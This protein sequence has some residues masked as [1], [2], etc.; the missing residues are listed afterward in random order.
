MNYIEALGLVRYL[1]ATGT[2][3]DEA[4]LN[5]AIPS[6]LR[7]KIKETIKEEE[8]IILQPAKM[9]IDDEEHVEWLNQKDRSEWYYWPTLRQY[10]LTTKSWSNASVQSLD[11]ETDR[12]LGRLAPPDS[13]TAFDKRGLVLG[14]V[15]SGKTSNYTALIAKAADSGYRFFVVLSGIDNG[16]RLQT[17]RRLKSELVGG[18]QGIGVTL[19][20]IGR[21]WHEFT[22]DELHGD[23]R[24]GFVNNAALQGSQPVLLVIKKNGTVLRRLLHWL[25]TGPEDIMKTIP[26]MV[27]DDE[28]DL[29][30]PDT[31]GSYQ[32]EEDPMPE[33]YE[34]PSVINGL[35]RDLLNRF[36]HKVYVAYTATPFA[37]ILI[38][39]DNYDP[40]V[41]DD[42]YPRNFMVDLPKP[43]GYFG[44]EELFGRM[45][46]ISEEAVEGID[47]IRHI[48]DEDLNAL[49]ECQIPTIMEQAILSFILAGAARMHRSPDDFPATMLIHISLRIDDQLQIKAEVEKK[50]TEIR[51]EW[52]YDR[53]KGIYDR[54]KRIWQED[55][56]PVTK[57]QHPSEVVDFDEIE[58]HISKFFESIQI[59]TINSATGEILDYEIEPN[60]KAIAIGGN[61]LS[62]GLTLE[63]LLISVFIRRSVQY[64]TLMQ[65]GRWFGFRAGYDDLTRIYTTPELAQWFSD[66][67]QVECRLREE[68]QIFENQHL[69]PLQVGMK[70]K[71]HPTMQV[72]SPL[73]RRFSSQITI[74]QS[75]SGQIE[76]TIRWPLNRLE[77]LAMLSEKNLVEVKSFLSKLGEYELGKKGPIWS[78]IPAEKILNF[79]EK[80][81][82]DGS[83][84]SISLPLIHSY[85]EKQV[86]NGELVRWN[87]AICGRDKEDPNLGE[88]DWS[89]KTK[90][91]QISRTRVLDTESIKVLRSSSDEKI[92][93]SKEE[94]ERFNEFTKDGDTEGNAARKARSPNNGL[95][96]LYPISRFSRPD[97]TNTTKGIRRPLYNNLDD[98]RVRDLI[99]IAISFPYSTQ[100]QPEV[101]YVVGT[102]PRRTEE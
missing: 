98:P 54:L 64:D 83:S 61:K 46:D 69:T 84:R 20:P 101:S 53:K 13:R 88:V 11:K 81:T 76:Q 33:D 14:F 60:L 49:Q 39:H 42:L 37:N 44:A 36:D 102:V 68:I 19:P 85:I 99:G 17:H 22:R 100:P 48:S 32:S 6:E 27:I 78:E 28:A 51:D 45:D 72:T 7:D 29:A 71:T 73:K 35:I 70:I 15:Q 38:P 1:L 90:I 77:E 58:T 79:L 10:L 52:R 30:S 62:R 4:I 56:V 3:L 41:S 25:K 43:H 40:N 80:F 18:M 94:L 87:V 66:L 26:M 67:A 34:S 89:L 47:V 9:V 24:P 74:S 21:R 5:P 75:Y 82:I 65:M 8:T 31:R 97:N 91:K 2:T 63:G 57:Q 59:R 23:F 16:L 93:L 86:Q 50:F 95:I 12:I 96:L 92:G 55:F